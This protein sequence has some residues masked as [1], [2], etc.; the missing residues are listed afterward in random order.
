MNDKVFFNKG[1]IVRIEKLDGPAMM[2]KEVAKRTYRYT[3]DKDKEKEKVLLFGIKC[4]WFDKN[5]QLHEALFN[6]KDLIKINE[7]I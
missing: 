5:D 7:N 4:I 1:E 2:V 3:D 6:T